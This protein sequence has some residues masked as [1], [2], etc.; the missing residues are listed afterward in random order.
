MKAQ[1]SHAHHYVPQWYQKRF[2]T[3]GQTNFYLL[4]LQPETVKWARGSHTKKTVRRRG[5]SVCFFEN[6]LYTLRFGKQTTDAM[7]RKFFGTIDSLGGEAVSQFAEHGGITEGTR[8]AFDNLA[9]YMGAQRF[10]TPR[11]LDEIKK[12]AAFLNGAAR[13]SSSLP[14]IRLR[15]IARNCF[16]VSGSTQM[17]HL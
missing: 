3:P 13:R 7:E 8:E 4:D 6:D 12:R 15:S 1:Q 17:I 11:G 14:T 2:L 16:R 9:P 5:P 10:R